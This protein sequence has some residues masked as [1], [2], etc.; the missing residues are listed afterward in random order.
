MHTG[1]EYAEK[2]IDPVYEK[3]TY[4]QLDCQAFCEK[5]L[6]DIGVRNPATGKPYN[7]RGSNHIARTACS[8]IGSKEE[9]ITKFGSI[10][11]GS[12]AFIWKNDGGEKDRG[13]HD[14]IG[15]YKHIGIY[16]GDNVV[17][18]ST[19]NTAR[20]RNGPA[21]TTLDR[22]NRI[23]IPDML[24]FSETPIYNKEEIMLSIVSEIRALLDKLEGV[25]K[26]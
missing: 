16:V 7:W 19:R 15:N 9:C 2:A 18:D 5:V 22:F 21:A 10:P 17:M 24:D 14:N 6:S 23:G 11:V 26:T 3:Y 12:W 25:I 20:T 13:Y 1:K 4:D 8:W